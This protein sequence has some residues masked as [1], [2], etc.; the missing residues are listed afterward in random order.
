LSLCLVVV[1]Q[2]GKRKFD[3]GHQNQGESK[4][5]Y[6]TTGGGGGGNTGSATAGGSWGS[7]PIPQQPLNN[8]YSGLSASGGVNGNSGANYCS[9]TGGGGDQQWYQDSYGQSWS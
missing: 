5:R 7:Q 1:Y 8:T 4:R 2:T 6:Q 9:P 3:G